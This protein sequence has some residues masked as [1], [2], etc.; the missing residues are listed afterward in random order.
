MAFSKKMDLMAPTMKNDIGIGVAKVRYTYSGVLDDYTVVGTGFNVSNRQKQFAMN[1]QWGTQNGLPSNYYIMKF[2]YRLV[3]NLDLTI[4]KSVR[5]LAGT[6][7]QTVGTLAYQISPQDLIS[8]RY[9]M[10]GNNQNLFF[11]YRH[12]GFKGAEYYLIYGD[13]NALRTSN[14]ISIKA[15]WAF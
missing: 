9:V 4:N 2:G 1:Y 13:P 5:E 10:R 7:R 8:S 3:K 11:S 6:A 15:V 12:A 14:R